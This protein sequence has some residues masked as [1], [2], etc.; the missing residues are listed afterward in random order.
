[1]HGYHMKSTYK[2]FYG[3][4]LLLHFVCVFT[5]TPT[6]VAVDFVGGLC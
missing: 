6:L 1:M 2:K 5:V 3:H 4:S